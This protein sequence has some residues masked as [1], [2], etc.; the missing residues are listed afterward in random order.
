MSIARGDGWHNGAI[1]YTKS[2]KAMPCQRCPLLLKFEGCPWDHENVNMTFFDTLF[3]IKTWNFRVVEKIQFRSVSRLSM[4]SHL[5]RAV[6]WS[7]QAKQ[8]FQLII[9]H[10]CCITTGSH[11]ASS[12]LTS[13]EKSER[14]GQQFKSLHMLLCKLDLFDPTEL[15]TGWYMVSA[16]RRAWWMSVFAGAST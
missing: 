5:Q 3:T 9:H 16:T 4:F 15:W 13:L 2:F 11:F 6:I 7:H 8:H 1:H 10:S 12:N 14:D